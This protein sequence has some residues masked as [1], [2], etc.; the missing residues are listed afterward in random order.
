MLSIYLSICTTFPHTPR[1][2]IPLA[3]TKFNKIAHRRSVPRNSSLILFNLLFP[4]LTSSSSSTPHSP[5]S[6]LHH[7][8][9]HTLH[10]VNIVLPPPSTHFANLLPH[11]VRHNLSTSNPAT[12]DNSFQSPHGAHRQVQALQRSSTSASISRFTQ[13]SRSF[14]HHWSYHS[15]SSRR[16]Q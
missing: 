11:A 10:A 8:P 3:R 12:P 6:C 14:T 9:H 16:W 7:P 4:H 15:S 13:T 2:S 1:V 5:S